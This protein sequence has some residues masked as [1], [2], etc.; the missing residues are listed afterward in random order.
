MKTDTQGRGHGAP[1]QDWGD[2]AISPGLLATSQAK[3]SG[4]IF[5]WSLWENVA[6]LTPEV[7]LLAS[8]TV[9]DSAFRF[10]CPQFVAHCYS[11][12]GGHKEGTAA[13]SAGRVPLQPWAGRPRSLPDAPPAKLHAGE[14]REHGPQI[15][16][17]FVACPGRI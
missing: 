17:E 13:L 7:G 15:L 14:I 1:G 5:S 12:P 4:Q 2:A 6:P 11:R 8:R 3:G 9:R 10:Q 16:T